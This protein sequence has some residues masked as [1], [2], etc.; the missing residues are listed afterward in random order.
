MDFNQ[1]I[2]SILLF[3]VFLLIGL[4]GFFV[5]YLFI[6]NK[7]NN[8][9]STHPEDHSISE[10][11]FCFVH[12]EVNSTA[13]CSICEEDICD[14]CVKQIDKLSLCPG[15]LKTYIENRWVSITNQKTTPDTPE[16]GVY[17][18]NFKKELWKQ[19]NIPTYIMNEYKINVEDDFIE[20]YVQLYV[21]EEDSLDLDQT[22][23]TSLKH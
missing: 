7:F 2:I 10:V 21:R 22:I 6:K 16:A 17:I 20:T 4:L 3:A 5:Y 14:Q 11:G 15:H 18:Y 8:N 13:I 12:R 9:V 23:N 1:I 19:Q